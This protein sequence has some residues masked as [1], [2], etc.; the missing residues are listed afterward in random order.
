MAQNTQRRRNVRL[1]NKKEKKKEANSFA[2]LEV[3]FWFGHGMA[4]TAIEN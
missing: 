2:T 3:A 4:G 1:P